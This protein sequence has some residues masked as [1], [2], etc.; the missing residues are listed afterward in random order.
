MM[1]RISACNCHYNVAKQLSYKIEMLWRIEKQYI[2]DSKSDG[3]KNCVEMWKKI[4]VDERKHV[5]IL[6]QA[7]AVKCKAGH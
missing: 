4:A 2:T 5:D 1:A 3:H 6:K 7:L